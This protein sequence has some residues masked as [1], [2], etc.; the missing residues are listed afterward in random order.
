MLSLH[1]T[2]IVSMFSNRIAA[3]FLANY[4]ITVIAGRLL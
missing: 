2:S 3:G 4:I 1:K